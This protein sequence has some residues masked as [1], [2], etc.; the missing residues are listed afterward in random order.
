L[1]VFVFTVPWQNAMAIGGSKT[2]SSIIGAAALA[3]TVVACLIG[4][5]LR[6]P[7]V[8]LLAFGALIAWQ[9]ASYFWSIE[10]TAT[11]VR[12]LT[13]VQLLAMVWA[14]SELTTGEAERLWVIQAF[15]LGCVVVCCVL[16]EAYLSGQSLGGF[17]Y[18]PPGFNQ[19]ESADVV[20][21]GIPLALLLAVSRGR[22]V[23]RWLNVAYVPVAIF[24]VI[25]TASRSGFIAACL[26]LVSVFFALRQARSVYRLVWVAIV[27]GV[28]SALFFGLSLSSSL[29][30]NIERITFSTDTRSLETLT[31][32]TTIWSAGLGMFAERPV[33]GLGAGTFISGLESRGG[34]FHA[35]HNI[36]VETA[37]E[38]GIVGVGLLMVVFA[39]ALYPAV[40][41]RGIRAK[42]NAVLFVVLG[43]TSF[44]ANLMNNKAFWIVLAILAV[45]APVAQA[46]KAE[47][48]NRVGTVSGSLPVATGTFPSPGRM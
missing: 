44:V 7:P 23:Y 39:A 25:L 9:L 18:A 15:V 32:R 4:G 19:N 29:D 45:T 12:L 17:R 48:N 30:S 8:L 2:L 47:E 27:I 46:E 36:W 24:A 6:R 38:T 28:F 3:S 40:K 5:R 22:G 1:L 43:T 42:F 34:G 20:A 13:M 21:M 35:A 33:T 31:G 37:A 41:C 10:P 26:A 16:I 14:I 11:L